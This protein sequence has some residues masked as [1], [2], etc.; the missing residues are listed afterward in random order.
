MDYDPP[1]LIGNERGEKS[2]MNLRDVDELDISLVCRRFPS[3]ILGS[4][5]HVDLY[6]GTTSYPEMMNI[7]ATKDFE[8]YFSDPSEARLVQNTLSEAWPSMH[9]NHSNVKSST[10]REGESYTCPS[11]PHSLFSTYE[12]KLDHQVALE[13]S[14]EKVG[15]QSQVELTPNGLF[16]DKSVSCLPG[17]S[18]RNCRQLEN[19]GFHT[20]SS[21]TLWALGT[22]SSWNFQFQK[23]A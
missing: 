4:A 11:S 9:A 8:Q 19:C 6:D 10:L 13:D 21:Q 16:L 23:M 12:E 22:C 2:E 3:I 17:L 20:V 18:K 1:D 5:P 15:L 14:L 7:L